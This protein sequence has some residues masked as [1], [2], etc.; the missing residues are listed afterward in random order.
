MEDACIL[1]CG[2]SVMG[3]PGDPHSATVWAGGCSPRCVLF[4]VSPAESDTKPERAPSLPITWRV[5]KLQEQHEAVC[6]L[7]A[8]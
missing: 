3:Y 6:L 8:W 4:A 7:S 2:G 1:R 5:N